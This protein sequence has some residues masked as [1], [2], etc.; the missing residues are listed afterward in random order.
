MSVDFAQVSVGDVIPARRLRFTRE[1]VVE[2]AAASGDRNRIHWDETYAREVGLPGVIAHGMLTMG[3][4]SAVVEEWAGPGAFVAA[5]RTK[6][7]GL[8]PVPYSGEAV[9]EVAGVVK[10][11]EAETRSAVVELQVTN[12]GAKVLGNA[13]LTVRW[14]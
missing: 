7:T 6:F 3:S 12:E 10:A 9:V 4:A 8:V 14:V 2:Y 1:R 13:R 5:Y 11:V